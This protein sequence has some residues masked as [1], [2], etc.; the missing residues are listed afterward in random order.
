MNR[1]DFILAGSAASLLAA[2]SLNSLKAAEKS[3][4]RLRIAQFGTAHSHGPGKWA[5]LKKYPDTFEL[6]GICEPDP[7]QRKEATTHP[8]YAGSRWIEEKELWSAPLDAILVESELPDLIAMG[9]QVLERGYHLHL[10]KPPGSNLAGFEQLQKLAAQ[11]QRV[12]QT[13]YMFRYHPAFQ[14]CLHAVQ[15][16]MLGKVFA[17]H[18]DIGSDMTVERRPWLA[19]A[20]GGSMLL[21]GSHLVDLAVALLGEP[22]DVVSRRHQSF[23]ERDQ[24]SDNEVAI[25]DYKNASAV[26][27][28]INSE[29]GGGPRRQFLV[30][31][32]NGTFEWLP[33]EPARVKLTLKR[34]SGEYKAGAQEVKIP[35]LPGR[36]DDML[37]DFGRMCRGE[38]TSNPHFT[39]AF[40]LMSHAAA[41]KCC[42]RA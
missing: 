21:L 27:R 42:G 10:D 26:I 24:Y 3:G 30:F 18:G 5:T 20:Y 37:L 41:L 11:K 29:V 8:E 31:G 32:E 6:L 34:A 25:L 9:R 38:P 22:L 13:G 4:T 7:A 23:P 35:P 1:R 36:Y 12:L 17:I 16:G 28:C 39:P 2:T 33:L 15:S 40:D 19:K 14:F